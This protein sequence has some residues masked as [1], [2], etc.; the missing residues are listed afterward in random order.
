MCEDYLGSDIH[1][2]EMRRS[3]INMCIGPDMEKN[4]RLGI[5]DNVPNS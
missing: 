3:N 1:L 5:S 4:S 2:L